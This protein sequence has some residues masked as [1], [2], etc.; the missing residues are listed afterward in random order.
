MFLLAPV[1][2]FLLLA[3]ILYMAFFGYRILPDRKQETNL[4][5]K[6]SVREYLAEIELNELS[7]STGKKIMDAPL[8]KQLELDIIEV[9]RANGNRH[10]LP[11][12]DLVL[13]PGDTLKVH[14]NIDKLIQ[15]KEQARMSPATAISMN[16][17]YLTDK[18]TSLVELIITSKSEFDGKSLKELDFRRK[19]RAVPLAIKH[20]EEILHDRLQE[21]PLQAGDL[22]LA[23]VKTHFLENLKE[24]ENKQ[25]S[26][27]IVLSEAGMTDF[28]RKK[29]YKVAAIG[30]AVILAATFE[31]LPI[32]I[33][34]IAGATLL[35]LSRCINM[36]E[37][38]KAIEW[39]V[40]FLLAGAL[41]L[42]VAMQNSGLADIIAGG[43]LRHLGP[44]G[45]VAVASGI[46]L[47]TALLTEIMSNNATAA[48]IAP[49]AIAMAGSMGVSPLP[50]LMAV[51]FAA[52]AGF[53][54]PVG[55]QT[56]MM[57]FSAGQY[58]FKDFVK[59]GSL[60]SLIFW[61]LA[62]LLI[63]YFF[64]F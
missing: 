11:P 52:S 31:V 22:I 61:I 24:L 1:G 57:I 2:L 28:D 8:V 32:M 6:F 18:N 33:A 19:Y 7:D 49:I 58:K 50:F 17:N 9:R 30:G 56:H 37:F 34:T 14:F 48:L 60:L 62:S 43:L 21:V 39:K 64:P 26:P 38:Y 47:I 10:Y 40:V 15:L 29:F 53:M 3:G 20:R 46:Y 13:L 45:P 35:V 55:Y 42:G 16:N 59:V 44:L 25:E 23:E 27:F 5:N 51:T 41:S 12:G 36:K 54:S 4:E 63:P